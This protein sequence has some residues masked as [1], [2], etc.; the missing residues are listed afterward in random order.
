MERIAAHTPVGLF[1]ADCTGAIVFA[2]ARFFEILG[3]EPDEG[4]GRGWFR[5]IEP[6]DRER[7]QAAWFTVVAD[8]VA[9]E[10]YAQLEPEYA[11]TARI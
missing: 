9:G 3:V 1:E 11:R 10:F 7:F 4:L 8:G 6:Q 2:T 5:T